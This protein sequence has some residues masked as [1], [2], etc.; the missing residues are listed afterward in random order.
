MYIEHRS[1][2][3]IL[4]SFGIKEIRGDKLQIVLLGPFVDPSCGGAVPPVRSVPDL[5]ELGRV[6]ALGLLEQ[7]KD[8]SVWA[9]ALGWRG[10]HVFYQSP[11]ARGVELGCKE[12]RGP[13]GF[14]GGLVQQ[15]QIAFDQ[16]A[17][18]G[19]FVVC[20]GRS[21][22]V[23]HYQSEQVVILRDV[24]VCLCCVFLHL[25]V[26]SELKLGLGP[27]LVGRQRVAHGH[28]GTGRVLDG[29]YP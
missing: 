4:L 17:K 28:W 18:L 11:R 3:I 13:G 25:L 24:R 2:I 16:V 20:F 26:E 5:G 1:V 27:R 12:V 9:R 14:V 21:V 22:R 15:L 23:G 7:E 8:I 6:H 10:T 19:P 29:Q